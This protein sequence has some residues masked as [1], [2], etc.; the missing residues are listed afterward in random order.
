MLEVSVI[1]LSALFTLIAV[2]WVAMLQSAVSDRVNLGHTI[3][4]GIVNSEDCISI[5]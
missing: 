4:P 2:V 1:A 3:T 5:C